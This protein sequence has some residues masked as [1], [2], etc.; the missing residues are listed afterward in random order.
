[1]SFEPRDYLRHVLPEADY[2]LTHRTGLPTTHSRRARRSGVRSFGASR[3]SAGKEVP[4]EFRGA[5]PD[6]EWRAMARMCDRIIHDYLG[7]DCEIVWR[8][9]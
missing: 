5:H 1:M 8:R 9:A 3:S 2:L 7:V 6:V 4:E